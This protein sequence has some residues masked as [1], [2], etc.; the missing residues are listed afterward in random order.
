MRARNGETIERWGSLTVV[1]VAAVAVVIS[2]AE[3]QPGG[4]RAPGPGAGP[5]AGRGPSGPSPGGAGGPGGPG[6]PG[7]GAPGTG[8]PGLGAP[9]VGTAP[10]VPVP[11]APATPAAVAVPQVPPSGPQAA[12][13]VA[14]PPPFTP[15]WYAQHPDAWQHP[16]PYAEWR[17]APVPPAAVVSAFFGTDGG[18]NPS[19]TASTNV[20]WLSL[21]VFSSPARAGGQPTVFHQL[22][23]S[24]AGQIKGVMVDTATGAVQPLSG[25]AEVSSGKVNWSVGQSGAL[26]YES[27]LDELLKQAAAVTSVTPAGR[28]PGTLVLVPAKD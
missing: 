28:Q 8:G 24:K 16:K 3:G 26:S 25:L 6:S 9:G 20:E 10:R 14:G 5:G 13:G 1:L 19:L 4:R 18:A 23:V 22:A 2:S 7:L 17:A 27:S 15:E 21:G 11:V 12:R